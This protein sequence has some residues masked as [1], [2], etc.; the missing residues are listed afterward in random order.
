[1]IK[2]ITRDTRQEEARIKWIKNKCRGTWVFATGVGKTYSAIKAIKSIIA[3][4]PN[5]KFIILVPTDNLKVQWQEYIDS[6]DLTFNGEV[7][8]LNTAIKHKYKTDIL[9][10]DECHRANSSTFREVF[11]TISY[12][13]VLGLTATFERLDNLHKEVMEKYCPVIDTISTEEALKNGW[14]SPFKEYQVLLDV[15]DIDVYKKY[16]KE[17][18]EHFEFFGF[19][20]N[21]VS[22]LLGKN[23]FIERSKLRDI[24]CPKG[25]SELRKK[26]FQEI[27]YHSIGFSRALQKRKTF[28]NNHPKKLEVC[29]KIIEAFP[30]KKIITFSNTIKMAE[31]IGI[32]KVYTGK[33]SKK[34]ARASLEDFNSQ[35]TGCI[36]SAKKLVEGADLS[37]LDV[38]IMLGIDSSETRAIQS[39]GRVI[40]YSPNKQALIFNLIIKDTVEEKWLANS[41]ANSPYTTIDEDGLQD[42]LNGKEPAPYRNKIKDYM[43]RF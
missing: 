39:R 36:N 40:R 1:M 35:T 3:K 12:K 2:Q 10:I 19:S 14:L 20:W 33:D 23:G 11:N 5:I 18:I 4:Y 8:I 16:N 25:T 17:F 21:L 31:A 29:R 32:G 7:I 41:H 27:T 28:I 22:K 42:I 24:M 9:V 26:V 15:D 38:A 30:N 37:G 43:Y 6:N 13:Y 34:K